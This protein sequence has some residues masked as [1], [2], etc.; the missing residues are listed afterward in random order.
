MVQ[1]KLLLENYNKFVDYIGKE[2][3]EENY[4][5]FLSDP[6]SVNHP[7]ISIHSNILNSFKFNSAII[8]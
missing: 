6:N 5:K 1:I 8:R 7:F 4:F 2:W 3:V